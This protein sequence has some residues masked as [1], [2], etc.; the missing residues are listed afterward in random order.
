[1]SNEAKSDA[2][3]PDTPAA[4]SDAA[5]P[6][7]PAPL[8][9]AVPAADAVLA[10]GAPIAAVATAQPASEGVATASVPPPAP[11]ESRLAAPIRDHL[12]QKLRAAYNEVA[13]KPAFLGDPTLPPVVEQQLVRLGDS[14]RASETG[15]HAVE[16][17]LLGGD[18]AQSE[19]DDSPERPVDESSPS[20]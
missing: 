6:A 15:L 9:D 3:E 17:A 16:E 4:A 12:G 14:V 5:A 18:P 19:T 2:A 8:A 20:T 11:G 7:D 10:D 1:M 13:E